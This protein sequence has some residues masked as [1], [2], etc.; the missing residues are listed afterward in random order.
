MALTA[1]VVGIQSWHALEL[2]T[3]VICEGKSPLR[4]FRS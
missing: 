3:F 4:Q 2:K 1:K